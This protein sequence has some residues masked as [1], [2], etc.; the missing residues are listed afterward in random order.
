MFKTLKLVLEC[1][2]RL[3]RLK[4]VLFGTKTVDKSEFDR[5]YILHYMKVCHVVV[6]MYWSYVY[7]RMGMLHVN[8]ILLFLNRYV[9]LLFFCWAE[10]ISIISS[11]MSLAQTGLKQ[12]CSLWVH[13][14]NNMYMLYMIELTVK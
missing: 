1:G 4:F 10:S 3:C 14:L 8:E 2:L 11:L 7:C 13:A 6:F 12:A 5:L 9:V